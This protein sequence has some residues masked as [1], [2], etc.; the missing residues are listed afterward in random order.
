VVAVCTIL[1]HT[2]FA[3]YL[4]W[5]MNNVRVT[6]TAVAKLTLI[7]AGTTLLKYLPKGG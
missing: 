4:L 7:L 2:A 3:S 5:Q 6:G 1:K